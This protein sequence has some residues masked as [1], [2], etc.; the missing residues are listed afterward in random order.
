MLYSVL[1]FLFCRFLNYFFFC[2]DIFFQPSRFDHRC[3]PKITF[4]FLG[5]FTQASAS[6]NAS[7]NTC[8]F[9]FFNMQKSIFIQTENECSTKVL[10]F[11]LLIICFIFYSLILSFSP[12]W[13]FQLYFSVR[14]LSRY[15]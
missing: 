4:L 11:Q 7:T 6:T 8:K 2:I 15:F 12:V 10:F 14:I 13:I 3:F 5:I 1:F 9:L